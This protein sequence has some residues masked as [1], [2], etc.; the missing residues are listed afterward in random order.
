MDKLQ[1]L[2]ESIVESKVNEILNEGRVKRTNKAKKKAWEVKQ[3]GDS[4]RKHTRNYF[5]PDSPSFAHLKAQYNA[6]DKRTARKARKGEKP[7]NPQAEQQGIAK[8]WNQEA[9]ARRSRDDYEERM[10]PRRMGR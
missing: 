7:E 3:G 10:K 9:E 5:D 1:S 8:Q 4:F 6:A 2:I